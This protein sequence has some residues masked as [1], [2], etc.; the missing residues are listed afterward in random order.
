MK[1]ET[2]NMKIILLPESDVIVT[3]GDEVTPTS[4]PGE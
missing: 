4:L 2:P 3:S 1:H